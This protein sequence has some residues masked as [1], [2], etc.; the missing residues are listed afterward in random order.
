MC[1]DINRSL[2]SRK[3]VFTLFVTFLLFPPSDSYVLGE[4]AKENLLEGKFPRPIFFSPISLT[5][6]EEINRI[7]ASDGLDTRLAKNL[8][9]GLA[10][11]SIF[12]ELAVRNADMSEVNRLLDQLKI[13]RDSGLKLFKLAYENK[14]NADIL[15][16][17]ANPPNIAALRE[18][19]SENNLAFFLLKKTQVDGEIIDLAALAALIYQFS[20]KDVAALSRAIGIH[21]DGF[22]SQLAMAS[23]FLEE[24]YSTAV[25]KV[26][27]FES[28]RSLLP[29]TEG[30]ANGAAGNYGVQIEGSQWDAKRET[31][32]WSRSQQIIGQAREIEKELVARLARKDKIAEED[33]KKLAKL[34]SNYDIEL[35]KQARSISDS[36][37]S[38]R[39]ENN[40]QVILDAAAS[41]NR[42]RENLALR[43]KSLETSTLPHS[44]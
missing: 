43:Q 34:L 27:G 18:E 16:L 14:I 29:L 15:L 39:I 42:Q 2:W 38:Q 44:E 35:K 30:K 26:L 40:S 7:L 10:F 4:S 32:A 22:Y 19:L 21:P 28:V 9:L 11:G 37:R 31:E 25:P 1:N 3:I 17:D 24:V 13:S 36:S 12:L 5:K 6:P 23:H 8:P 41:L 33:A 20:E